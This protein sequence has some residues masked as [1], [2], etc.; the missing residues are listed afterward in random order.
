MLVEAILPVDT[1]DNNLQQPGATLV[2]QFQQQE[3]THSPAQEVGILVPP[4]Q[5]EGIQDN[6]IQDQQL[7]QESVQKY[8]DGFKL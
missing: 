4:Q 8:K 7:P 6:S 2:V 3:G 1:L 5:L